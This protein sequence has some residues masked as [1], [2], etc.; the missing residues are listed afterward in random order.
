MKLP[1]TFSR[2]ALLVIPALFAVNAWAG[3]VVLAANSHDEHKASRAADHAPI[4]VMGDHMHQAGE[5][6][7]SY[8]FMSMHM[9]DNLQGDDD[10]SNDQIVTTIAN[11]FANPPM[12]PSTL[13][14]A[15]TEM[16]TDM[17]MIGVMYAPNDQV[18]LMAMINYLE[19]EMDHVTY[20]GGMGTTELGRFTT[21]TSGL[22]DTRVAALVKLYET[23]NSRAHLNLGLSIPTGDIE[24][25]DAILTPMGMTP[26]PR[27]PYPMQLGSGT[28]DLEPGITWLGGDGIV[29]WG[30]QY[31]AVIRLDN[32][33]EHYSLGD[34]H[35][36]TGWGS[37]SVSDGL[38]TSLRLTYTDLDSIDGIDPEIA[39]PVQ[40]AD[41]DNSGWERLDLGIGFNAVAAGGHRWSLEYELP[42]E[43][44]VNGV[45]MEM[46]SMFTAGYQY[47][48]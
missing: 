14:V 17:H 36:I 7:V 16:T 26:S 35:S 38:S 22:G 37:Y 31:K 2:F 43:Q 8:R 32:N 12:M 30:A 9:E 33:N 29:D 42:L 25:Q 4:G 28:W 13:R 47:A 48:F 19:K 10:I 11:R 3:D 44:D 41:P 15:P 20:A 46:Q 45:Q 27:L 39:L 23:G 21:R 24:E 34:K 40:T 18:T 6:M 1:S 5:W